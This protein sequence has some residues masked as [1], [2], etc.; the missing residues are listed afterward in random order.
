MSDSSQNSNHSQSRLRR[1]ALAAALAWTAFIV[2]TAGW[3]VFEEWHK[4]LADARHEAQISFQK[5]MLFRLWEDGHGVG[6]AP[7]TNN[8]PPS[9]R[10][11]RADGRA[12]IYPAAMMDQ[13]QGRGQEQSGH[14]G[15]LAGLKP[16]RPQNAPDAW[17]ARALK[18]FEKGAT[19]VSSVEMMDGREYMRVMRP[20]VTEAGCVTCHSAQDYKA[21]NIRGGMSVSVP[22]APLWANAQGHLR[23]LVIGDGVIWLLGLAV[24]GFGARRA[25]AHNRERAKATE[26][27]QESEKHLKEAQRL[28]RVGSWHW[29][30]ATDTVEWSE[31]LYYITGRDP[32]FPA[33]RY[34]EMSSC[35]TPESWNRL[36]AAVAKALRTG[37]SYELELEMARPDG[38]TRHTITRGE[39]DYDTAGKIVGLHGAVQ[40]ITERK[41]AEAAVRESE[42][43]FRAV[44]EGAA[45]PMFVN[46][47]MKFAYLNPAALRL[48]GAETPEQLIGQ[49]FLSRVH[50]DYHE[51]IEQRAAKVLQEQKGSAPPLEE[52]YLRLDGT[53]VPV[54]VTASPI[55][56]QGQR[57]AVVFLQDITERKQAERALKLFRTLVDRTDD[58]IEVVDP[59][60]GRFLDINE[61]GCMDAGYSRE[62]FLA[63]SVPD[64]DPTVNQ[65]TFT[66][67][68]EGIRKSGDLTWEGLR[69]RKDGSTFPVE[70]N[71]KYVRLDRDYIVSA[72]RD[73]TE[74]KRAEAAVRAAE[75]K[76]RSLVE[77]LPAVVYSA[78]PGASGL[79]VLIS[80]QI[81][82]MTGFTA[83]EWTADSGLWASRLHPDDRERV[84]AASNRCKTVGQV[85]RE[86]YRMVARDGREVW[87]RD[88]AAVVW[89]A[90]SSRTLVQGVMLDITEQKRAEQERETLAREKAALLDSADEGIYGVDREGRCIFF[91]KAGAAMLGY[92][93]EELLG[94]SLADKSLHE[95][96][97]HARPDG[98]P[99]PAE[100]CPI[101]AAFRDGV[102]HRADDEVFWRRDGTPLPVEYSAH[103]IVENGGVRGAVVIFSDITERRRAAES[104]ARLATAVEQ[105]AETI[106]ITDANAT[107]LYVNPAFER[108]TGYTR[109]EAIG[110]NPRILKSGKHDAEF[111]RR[112]WAALTAGQVWSGHIINKR[113]DGTLFE[114]DANISPVRDAAGQIV[115]YVAVRRDVTRE[116]ELENQLRQAQKMESVG[117]LAG[118][119]AHDF[120]NLLMAIMGYSDMT[121]KGLS[122]ND[123]LR[124]HIE[125]VRAAGERA[126]ALTRQLLAFSRKQVLQP[127]VLDLNDLVGNL[128]RMLRR[129]FGVDIFLRPTFYPA[130]GRVKADP[131]QIEQVITNLAVN[132][133]DAM[134]EG[135]TLTIRTANAEL[136]EAY[137]SQHAEVT[138]GR[139]VLLTVADTGTGMTDEVKA[140]LFEP[141]FTTK[142]VGK[143]TGLGLATI[144][145]IVKQSGGHITVYSEVG[146]GTTFK[147]Y[148]PR[149]EEGGEVAVAT[150]APAEL[151]CGTETILLVEDEDQVRNLARSVLEEC[152]Y[153]V[154]VAASGSEALRLAKQHAGKLDLLLTDMVMP[155][156]SG[157]VL[158]KAL[159][160]RNPTMGFIF[161]SGYTDTGILPRDLLAEGAAFLQK[162]FTLDVLA[163]KVRQVLDRKP[164][165]PRPA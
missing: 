92:M 100:A 56:Y 17:E 151:P 39:A 20:L 140:H 109:E 133:R 161:M 155:G 82:T 130:V 138:A 38:T 58:A 53:P 66:K 70:V 71:I 79:N 144:Y 48:L 1:Y 128:S 63:L 97:H 62:E 41:R 37:E 157:R 14:R 15:H 34:A 159:Q 68:M 33:P 77:R 111:Y 139:Y 61:K 67:L 23:S 16:L 35:Y 142:G 152:G 40:D 9:P 2:A 123:P 156:I 28:A 75:Q 141:F 163:R 145:G 6:D 12:P 46:L 158:A 110:Q 86:E 146:H 148:L 21:G 107:I 87:V 98:S 45:V 24:I 131:G 137:A 162:P 119:V 105:A 136:D 76:Y 91:N 51:I 117:R 99:Y 125:E 89:D 5:E 127:K 121:L 31:H 3:N 153:A 69:R 94:K 65:S 59:Q 11:S 43:R 147:I 106:V 115:N 49:P 93:P 120:N 52:V 80:P 113:K 47:E 96:I 13:V 129:V 7:A 85:L 150:K 118:G 124:K 101:R 122:A 135:G 154:L 44:V 164:K 165:A 126:T 36:S 32:K 114:E 18:A 74:R 50:P 60:T 84:V 132:A 42:E 22:L 149:V 19:E 73:I 26:A 102:P 4:T 112:M 55:I 108:T 90:A 160:P 134:P 95:L 25:Q 54:E 8:A 27:L 88:E 103:P 57:G 143:G 104:Q 29:T 116:A 81:E 64:I 78:E 10:L 30:A 83:A 72:V